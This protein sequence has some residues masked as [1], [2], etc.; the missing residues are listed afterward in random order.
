MNEQ[1]V[2]LKAIAVKVHDAP[3]GT[4]CEITTASDAASEWVE[5]NL[6]RYGSLHGS[7]NALSPTLP[8][9]RMFGEY[10]LFIDPNYNAQEVTNYI[11]S[12]NEPINPSPFQ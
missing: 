6:V 2:A 4:F 7:K 11:E 1:P 12:Y 5:I 10:T 9:R 3:N 8:G